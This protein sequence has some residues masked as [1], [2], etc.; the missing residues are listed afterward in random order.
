M[1]PKARRIHKAT[2]G[3]RD[4]FKDHFAFEPVIGL[5]PAVAL[6]LL[7]DE[8]GPREVYEGDS[9]S[10]GRIQRRPATEACASA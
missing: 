1:D 9:A 4:C 10:A 8:A 2:H 5:F 3:R 6:E 7:A